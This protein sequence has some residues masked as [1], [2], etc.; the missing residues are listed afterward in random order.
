MRT[1]R[2]DH[3]VWTS[4]SILAAV[5]GTPDAARLRRDGAADVKAFDDALVEAMTLAD[6]IRGGLLKEFPDRSTAG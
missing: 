5:A 6:A 4:Q 3:A 2:R 1:L